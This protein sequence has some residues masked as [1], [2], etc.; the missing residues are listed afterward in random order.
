[1]IGMVLVVES[2]RWCLLLVNWEMVVESLVGLLACFVTMC[3]CHFVI[4]M[5]DVVDRV[6]LMLVKEVVV[7]NSMWSQ[8]SVSFEVVDENLGAVLV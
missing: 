8:M 7:E 3:R 6:H 4:M 2:N 5:V 1:M